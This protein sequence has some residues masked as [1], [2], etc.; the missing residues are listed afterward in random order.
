MFLTFSRSLMLLFFI[1]I[2][3]SCTRQDT[4]G[5]GKNITESEYSEETGEM[6]NHL[7]TNNF[8][9]DIV[10]HP[11]FKDFGMM[12]PFKSCHPKSDK[13]VSLATHPR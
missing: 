1:L 5:A 7:T 11:A 3:S 8:I 13:V 4:I 10:N 9:R 6:Y 12:I 2:L